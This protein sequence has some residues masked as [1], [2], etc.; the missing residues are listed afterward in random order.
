MGTAA[1]HTCPSS[2]LQKLV[3]K[4]HQLQHPLPSLPLVNFGWFIW[5]LF[6]PQILKRT[7]FYLCHERGCKS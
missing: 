1:E 6:L 3:Q 7:G 4:I 2:L 5:S